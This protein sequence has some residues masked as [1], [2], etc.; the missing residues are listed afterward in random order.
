[1]KLE[2]A[3]VVVTGSAR[4]IGKIIAKAFIDQC[5]YVIVVDILKDELTK[6]ANELGERAFSFVVDITDSD[7][8][9][10]L[11]DKVKSRFGK[12]DIL[13]NNAGTFSVIGPVWEVDP[14]MWFRDIKT[15]LFG[16]FLMCHFITNEMIKQKSGYV[17][18]IVSSGGVGDPHAYSTSYASSKTGLMRLTEGLAKEIQEH[19]IKVFAV[20]PP[21]VLTDMTKFI[22]LDE[23][24]KKW[25]PEFDKIFENGHDAPPE[26]VA[27]A[28]LNLVSGKYDRLTGRYI[29]V[30]Q[31]FDNLINKTDEIISNDKLTL[32]IRN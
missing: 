27:E 10:Y 7:Q 25:R 1:M 15:N 13:I 20:A 19:G 31:D 32:R 3:V 14:Q 12:I 5:A 22:M 2:N 30:M 6:T 8:V 16:S 9:K 28:I 11:V 17:I 23:G 4:G 26:K 18:N 29:L 24:G 21:A